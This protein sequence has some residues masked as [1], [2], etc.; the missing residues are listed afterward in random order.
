MGI[1]SKAI[2]QNRTKEGK[3]DKKNAKLNSIQKTEDWARWT[4]IKRGGAI[5]CCGNVNI[6]CYTNW[7]LLGIYLIHVCKVVN[8]KYFINVNCINV[9]I[10]VPN[11]I[12]M[13]DVARLNVSIYSN[14]TWVVL[15]R[16]DSA[17]FRWRGA[18]G[19]FA[20]NSQSRTLM[21]RGTWKRI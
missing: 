3:K 8:V 10:L 19:Y 5:W 20:R 7:Y 1:Y 6:S 14:T 17:G 4:P 9:L 13:S 11:P 15:N 12:S 16:M 18:H 21:T 2:S